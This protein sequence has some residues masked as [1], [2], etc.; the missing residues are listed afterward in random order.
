MKKISEMTLE[1]LQDHALGL[2]EKNQALQNQVNQSGIQIQELQDLNKTL[3]KRNN[4]LLVKVEQQVNPDDP[5]DKTKE[6]ENPQVESCEDF[7]KRLI[8][9]GKK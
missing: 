8:L 1:E 2:T 9:G 3:Q 4:E 5:D 7:A 6:K